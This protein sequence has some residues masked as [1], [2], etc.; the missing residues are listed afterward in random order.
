MHTS[1]RWTVRTGDDL[2]RAVAGVRTARSMTQTEVAEMTG[3]DRTYLTRLENG[4]TV[5]QIERALRVLRRLGATVS[6][7]LDDDLA[8]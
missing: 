4:A 6:V 7:E 5:A 2:G 8:R 1:T 3:I